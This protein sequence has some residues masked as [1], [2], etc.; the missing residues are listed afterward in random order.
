MLIQTL[1]QRVWRRSRSAV[2]LLAALAVAGALPP[3]GAAASQ[4]SSPCP[5]ISG[6]KCTI[7]LSTGITMRYLEVGPSNGPVV[8]LLHGYTDTSRSLSL[9]MRDLHQLAP[10]LDIIDPDQRGHGDT[11][12]PAGATCPSAPAAC[13]T[14]IDFARDI[15][16]FMDAR[17][18]QRASVVGHSMGSLVAQELGL[19]TP[20]GSTGSY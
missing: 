15:I 19:S 6:P 5:D 10:E 13:F 20:I 2:R 18:I 1:I 9:V 12:M 8:F 14:P 16:A 3:A 4:G 11:S 17:H 7:Q